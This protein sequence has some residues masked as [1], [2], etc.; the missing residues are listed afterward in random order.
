MRQNFTLFIGASCVF[1]LTCFGPTE[2]IFA[3]PRKCGTV[4]PNFD[5]PQYVRTAGV[6]RNVYN[7]PVVFHIVKHPTD[8]YIGNDRIYEQIDRLNADFSG[9]NVDLV[10]VP[11]K[12]KEFVN[13]ETVFNF[14]LAGTDEVGNRALGIVRT[15]TDVQNI[16]LSDALYFSAEGGSTA[17]DTDQYLNIW[18]ANC[19]GFVSGFGTYPAQTDDYRQGVV[20]HTAYFGKNE[21]EEFNLGRTVTH[22]IGHYFGLPH[23]W[24]E[25]TDCGSFDLIADTPPQSSYYTGCPAYPQES[26]GSTDMS[27]N[28]MD[29]VRDECM[30]MFTAGQMQY[31]RITAE[32]YRPGLLS[33]ET[34]C[35]NIGTVE[36]IPEFSVYPNPNNGFFRII[37]STPFN[38]ICRL[39]LYDIRGRSISDREEYVFEDFGFQLTYLYRGVYILHIEQHATKIV[40][41]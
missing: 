33:D 34:T 26:C 27:M 31:M 28:F 40:V 38:G 17:W 7:I 9:S 19:G 2:E 1:F 8:D 24:E 32:E 20:I 4:L 30:M 18:V 25:T 37:F 23:I 22:E 36:E 39:R 6:P 29:Y 21:S 35:L 16:G 15:S 3:Q 14:C 41:N 12:F 5:L 10:R 11:E 13:E